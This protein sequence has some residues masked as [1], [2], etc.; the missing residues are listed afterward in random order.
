[1]A[2]EATFEEPL[3]ANGAEPANGQGK[4]QDAAQGG[5]GEEAEAPWIRYCFEVVDAYNYCIATEQ[6]RVSIEEARGKSTRTAK[7]E[8]EMPIF[9][10]VE[11]IQDRRNDGAVGA[12]SGSQS[13]W[14]LRIHSPQ[15]LNA[16]RSV[17]QYYPSQSLAETS[18]VVAWPYAVL[19]HHYDQLLEF[20]NRCRA[21]NSTQLCVRERGAA[22]HLEA[23]LGWL[24]DNVMFHVRAEIERNQRNAYT[25]KWAWVWLRPGSTV[26]CRSVV[27]PVP[28]AYV[29]KSVSSGVLDGNSPDYRITTWSMA[30][31]GTVFQRLEN[32][33]LLSAFDGERNCNHTLE[34]DEDAVYSSMRVLTEE[35]LADP[36]ALEEG[37]QSLIRAGTEYWK[38]TSRVVRWYRGKGADAPYNDVSHSRRCGVYVHLFL[39]SMH[40]S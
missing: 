31:N 23:L 26:L 5:E 9:D 7:K 30:W 16:L 34:E 22:I 29:L 25:W 38:A 39:R 27:D 17:V 32:A 4:V 10:V 15:I 13:S 24:D 33:T 14:S 37:I 2:P 18:V 1:M 35:E 21:K 12:S 20:K 40:W 6:S 8:A 11:S 36:D 28:R 19:C 3:T